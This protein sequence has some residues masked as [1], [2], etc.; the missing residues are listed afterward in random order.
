[1]TCVRLN[2]SV[3]VAAPFGRD[4]IAL[5]GAHGCHSIAMGPLIYDLL[6]ELPLVM[7]PMWMF[8]LFFAF[9]FVELGLLG[10]FGRGIPVTSWRRR[11]GSHGG[12][13]VAIIMLACGIA[14][15]VAF[16]YWLGFASYREYAPPVRRVIAI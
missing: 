10:L 14:I 12:K 3:T 5:R 1:M 16:L 7:L 8:P 9:K 11:W 2:S 15:M 13:A 6:H 4:L